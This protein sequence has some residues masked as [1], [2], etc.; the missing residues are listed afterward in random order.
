MIIE[1]LDLNSENTQIL[2]SVLNPESLTSKIRDKCR[3]FTFSTV[4]HSILYFIIINKK[5]TDAFKLKISTIIM[6][7]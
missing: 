2:Y 3:M 5:K 6:C 7:T 4:K 1:A